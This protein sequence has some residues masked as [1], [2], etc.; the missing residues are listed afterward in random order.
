MRVSKLSTYLLLFIFLSVPLAL[1]QVTVEPGV[2]SRTLCQRETGLFTY[3]IHN[4]DDSV[5]TFTVSRQGSAASWTSTVPNGFS[6]AAGESRTIYTYVTPLQTVSPGDYTLDIVVASGG[7]VQ[8][9]TETITVQDCYA[10]DIGS[11]SSTQTVCPDGVAQYDFT[12]VNSG[13]FL[14]TYKL[15]PQGPLASS[16][17]LS[18]P[19]KTLAA[20]DSSVI[21]V[22]VR[23]PKDNGDYSVTVQ[24]V[25]EKSN[26]VD[27][28][29]VDLDV[30]SCYD[31]S[32]DIA[33]N[34]FAFCERSVNTIPINVLN[35]G[36]TRNSYTIRVDGPQWAQLDKNRLTIDGNAR[37]SVN[38]V[39]A[40]D[41]GIA[42]DFT[43]G[44]SVLP[45]LGTQKASTDVHVQVN[46]CHGVGVDI[47]SDDQTVCNG[48][49]SEY[50]VLITNTGTEDKEYTVDVT[51]PDWVGLFDDTTFSL[52][53]SASETLTLV[54]TPGNDVAAADH[55][56]TVSATATD[57]SAVTVQAEDSLVVTTLPV[58]SC[59][60]PEMS[61]FEDRL[62]VFED[63]SLT[64]PISI[65]NKGVT[66]AH[67]NV[68]LTGAASNFVQ[69]SPSAVS[70]S[71]GKTE[72]AF[73]YIAP[74]PEL[75]LGDYAAEV[76]VR[77][78]DST[79]LE[80]LDFNIEVTDNAAR[81]TVVPEQEVEVNSATGFFA[82][83]TDSGVTTTNVVSRAKTFSYQW[84]YYL[85]GGVAVLLFLL[86][87]WRVGFFGKLKG[88]FAG[89]A[90]DLE[91]LE[92]LLD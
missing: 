35:A 27:S 76:S 54:A 38:L 89:D 21:K 45:E 90:D 22:F 86:I 4:A 36:T 58:A 81:Q 63:S 25:G 75:T 52:A 30:A 57:A 29:T 47:L 20:G 53:P 85:L 78:A 41:Y 6:L 24:A 80:R 46:Q 37:G 82:R 19:V 17:T 64:V 11:S 18:E 77:L 72:V 40:P 9:T 79:F 39:M 48:M 49:S 91:E 2:A 16:I 70:V 28:Y 88:W 42:G 10:A 56:L 62:V 12:L 44:V 51:L 68:I 61:V 32:V 1:A 7:D 31:Y 33:T 84:R 65:T 3:A 50:P 8:T 71:P 60:L 23:A 92:K 87:L 74:S 15:T 14:E 69:L 83:F 13:N 55:T 73:M 5:R 26:K 43:V 66:R 34:E 67:Y 59:Y